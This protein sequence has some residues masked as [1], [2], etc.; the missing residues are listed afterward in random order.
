MQKIYDLMKKHRD[1]LLYLV[2]GVLTT[3]V[4]L[5]CF[6]LLRRM[7]PGGTTVPTA[8]AWAVSVLFAYVTNRTWVFRSQAHGMAALGRE[9]AAFF[10]SRLFSG[11]LDIAIMAV[12]VDYLGYHATITKLASNVVVIILNYVLSKFL[13]FRSSRQKTRES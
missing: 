9:M 6:E 2:F 7:L 10:G 1:L 13:V 4:N 11:L 3:A 8:I 5:I 12:A